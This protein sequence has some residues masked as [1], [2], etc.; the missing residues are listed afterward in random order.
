MKI[1]AIQPL[2]LSDFPGH[3][4][5]IIFTVGCNMRCHYCHNKD[6]WGEN[7]QQVSEQDIWSFLESKKNKLDGVVITGGEPTIHS[8]LIPF[9]KKVKALGYKVKLNTNGGNA[10]C[11][12]EL[13]KQNLLDYIA[14]DVKA[15]FEN[16]NEVCGTKVSL[17]D[18]KESLLL[19][20]SSKVPHEFRTTWATEWL[21]EDDIES[22]KAIIPKNSKH[23]VQTEI[24]NSD[25]V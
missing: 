2:S 4:A 22:I 12:R 21:S 14:M 20:S 1:G 9:I 7:H 11:L 6:L 18:I 15:P 13:I 8:G 23:I 17:E 25:V 19:V 10:D 3:C 5:A 16:Y 24:S